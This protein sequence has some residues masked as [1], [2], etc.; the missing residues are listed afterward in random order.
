M[1]KD[2]IG[3]Q[4]QLYA[5]EE[6][7]L[8]G[9]KGDG[10]RLFRVRNAVGLQFDILADRCADISRLFFKGDNIGYFASC[11]YAAPAYYD[12][13]DF[14]K[15]FTAGFLTTCGLDNVGPACQNMGKNFSMHGSIAN[16]PCERIWWDETAEELC[17]HAVVNTGYLFG[18]KVCLHRTISCKKFFNELKVCDCVENYGDTEAPIMLLYHINMG[19]PM[20][21]EDTVVSIVSKEVRAR[22]ERAEEGIDAWNCMMAPVAQFQEQCYFH[23]FENDGKAEVYNP[24]LKKG[25]RLE[26]DL[27]ELPQFT[28]WKQMGI[29]DYVLGLEPG[30]CNPIGRIEAEKN[31]QLLLLTPGETKTFALN[32]FFYEEDL[33]KAE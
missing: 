30:T 20:L 31:G 33:S 25:M 5:V 15:N 4:S 27:K 19:Y 12:R 21:S 18:S 7:R 26:F 6:V 11:G 17:I 23:H 2:Y 16:M 3:H 10:M 9:G 13:N 24:I 1:W 22:D 8:M 32:F 14:L 29:R 28:Q